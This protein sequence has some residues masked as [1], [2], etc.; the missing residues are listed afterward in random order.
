MPFEQSEK[1][2]KFK[3]TKIT[4][5]DKE[6]PKQ[7]KEIKNPPKQ[8]YL[9]GNIELLKQNIISIVGSRN[10]TQNGEKLAKKFA[11]ELTMQKITIASGMAKGIDS[12]A[13]IGTMEVGGKTIAVLGNGFNNIFPKENIELYKEIIR[14]GGL[15]VSEYPPDTEAKSN[16]FLER[17]RIVSGLSIGVLVVE[18]AHRSGTSVTAKLAESQGRKVFVLPHEIDDQYGVGTNNLIKKGAILVTSTKDIIENFEFL[19]YIE[20]K[21]ACTASKDKNIKNEIQEQKTNKTFEVHLTN[22]IEKEVYIL[23]KNGNKEVNEIAKKSNKS[24]SEITNAL[25]MLELDGA[26]KKIAGGYKCI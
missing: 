19:E 24:I 7:L 18:A 22:K 1:G 17:N 6:Y 4:I 3:M 5:E 8:L 20:F 23:I 25:L 9:E 16:L 12:A 2:K 15:I 14:E 13:H 11:S 10:C 21:K 26:I